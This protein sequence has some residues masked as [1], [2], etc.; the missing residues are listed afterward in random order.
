T[1]RVPMAVRAMLEQNGVELMEYSDVA[2]YLKNYT[3]NE[4]LLFNAASTN[5]ALAL[6][7][8]S[9]AKFTLKEGEDPIQ[10]LK[11]IKSEHEIACLKQS[12]AK[13]GVAM[14]RFQMRLEAALAAGETVSE[15]MVAGWLEELRL[16]QP[17][18]IGE[19]FNTIAAYGP[20]AAMMHYGATAENHATLQKKGFLLVDSGAQ[21]LDK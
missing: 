14:V 4:T 12:H 7:A 15:L 1:A 21:F 2:S 5:Y 6:A 16:A 20:N 9:N 10:L 17:L 3:T 19:S 11:S 18:C 13:D 8:R